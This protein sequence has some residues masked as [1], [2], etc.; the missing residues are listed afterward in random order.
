[1]ISFSNARRGSP[2]LGKEMPTNQSPAPAQ[3]PKSPMR[4]LA[5]FKKGGKVKKTGIYKLH[6]GEE[7]TPVSKDRGAAAM[8]DNDADDEP[9]TPKKKGSGKRP[10]EITFRELQDGTVHARH[11]HKPVMGSAEPTPDAEEFSFGNAKQAAKHLSQTWS[12][13]EQ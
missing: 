9:K 6:K 2:V 7:V 11:S 3:M 10:S 5:S 13:E 8:S 12:P 4:P 1:M